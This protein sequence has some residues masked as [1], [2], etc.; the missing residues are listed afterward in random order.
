MATTTERR[1]ELTFN[2]LQAGIE[3][4]VLAIRALKKIFGAENYREFRRAYKRG[5]EITEELRQRADN[6]V[7]D[8]I[9]ERYYVASDQRAEFWNRMMD[10]SDST[11]NYAREILFADQERQAT[12]TTDVVWDGGR[13]SSALEILTMPKSGLGEQGRYEQ[14]RKLALA[15]LCAEVISGDENGHAKA[16]L[17]R[18]NNFLGRNL[19]I[20][21]KADPQ[22]YPT[23]SYHRPETNEL[24]GF[25]DQYPD[26]TFGE[27]L[28]VKSLGYPV[29]KIG[30]KNEDGVLVEVG[31]AL[32]DPRE[33][34]LEASVIKVLQR[35]L[36]ASKKTSE[37]ESEEEAESLPKVKLNGGVIETSPYT[38]DRIG[39]R[40][41][42]MEGGHPL[43]DR[44]TVYLKE[45]FETFDGYD[46]ER[47][48]GEDNEVDPD[49]GEPDRFRSRRLQV[50][51][52][53]LSKPLEVIIQSLDDYV[54]QLYEVGEFDAKPE[55]KDMHSGSA[56]DLYKLW[57][58]GEVAEYLWPP[59]IF[60][61]INLKESKT[62][63]SFEYATRLGR[64]Q[65]IYP[66][67]YAA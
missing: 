53:G 43:R 18:I 30:I 9:G 48:I 16:V 59:K 49:N 34:D 65:R 62:S 5:E 56:H 47:G 19:F 2:M 24:V 14:G 46:E 27:D 28:W 13:P 26:P 41:V 45:L 33:K 40:L 63:S 58:V 61:S 25:S 11:V 44:L 17:H 6:Y 10:L 54:T 3:S 21:R 51:L 37:E 8:Q 7:Y 35:S 22:N 31:Q 32:Y 39:L 60:P 23:Y 42:I 67:P 55:R 20:G 66:L 50:S 38:E 12:L 36:K 15:S 52:K 1:P 57:T 29:R 64:K 4:G